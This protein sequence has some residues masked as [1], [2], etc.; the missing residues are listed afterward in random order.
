MERKIG[1]AQQLLMET[2]MPIG[3]IAEMSSKE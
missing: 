3:E 1:E 2:D